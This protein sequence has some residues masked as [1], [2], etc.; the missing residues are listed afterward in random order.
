ML[1]FVCVVAMTACGWMWMRVCYLCLVV[2]SM[3]IFR[4]AAEA[5]GKGAADDARGDDEMA[6]SLGRDFCD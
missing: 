1:V 2:K 5:A 3:S 4:I 6:N